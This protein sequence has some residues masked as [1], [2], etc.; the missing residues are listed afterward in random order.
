MNI[1]TCQLMGGLGNQLFQISTVIAIGSNTQRKIVFTYSDV[2]ETG[3][4]RSTYWNN[5]LS[6][7]KIFTKPA[8][9]LAKTDFRFYKEE[10]FAYN[11][12]PN[13]ENVK[14]LWLYGYFQSYKYF[15]DKKD[16]LFKLLRL[17]QQ[18]DEAIK[19]NPALISHDHNNIAM[20]FRLG[21]YKNIQDC[22]PLMTLEYY[23]NALRF[24]VESKVE[25]SHRVLYFCQAEDDSIV[26]EY[27]NRLSNLF[28]EVTFQKVEDD[29]VDWKQLLLM[30]CC[31]DN[32]IANST[33]SWWGAYFNENAN[34]IVCYPEV[35]FGPK[36]SHNISDLFPVDW[37]KISCSKN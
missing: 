21:D 16:L 3:I 18:K 31:N 20:H 19:Q 4:I 33:F 30:S 5:F 9:E 28:P 22:H 10:S 15:E 8:V 12:P 11:P 29:I 35:W 7:L 6:G 37:H 2:L 34:K 1:I 36:L 17:T 14:N 27:I 24:I 23:E 32:I 25:S 26:A 13:F